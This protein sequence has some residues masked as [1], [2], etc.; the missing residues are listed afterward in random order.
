MNSVD[1]VMEGQFR[2][3]LLKTKEQFKVTQPSVSVSGILLGEQTIEI[4][5]KCVVMNKQYKAT[6]DFYLGKDNKLDGS[7]IEIKTGERLYSISGNINDKV[8]YTNQKNASK[9][10][11]FDT[12]ELKLLKFKVEPVSKQAPNCSRRNWHKCVLAIQKGDYETAAKEKTTV[13]ERERALR[14]EGKEL[15]PTLF[16]QKDGK[17]IFKKSILPPEEEIN[18]KVEDTGVVSYLKSWFV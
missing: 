8:H 4:F 9:K 16:E 17:W 5:D 3:D 14:K 2:I 13:E 7:V 18:D 11:L 12:T 10:T 15:K 6:I 1:A